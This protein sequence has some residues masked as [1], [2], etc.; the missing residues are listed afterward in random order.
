MASQLEIVRALHDSALQ[1]NERLRAEITAL[2]EIVELA[3][4][5]SPREGEQRER[6]GGP[7]TVRAASRY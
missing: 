6:T 3:Q 2:Q 4:L 1:E 5:T 7:R